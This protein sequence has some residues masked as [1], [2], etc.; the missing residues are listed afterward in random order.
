[1]RL[2][3]GNFEPGGWR[4]ARR[5]WPAAP[6]V[7]DRADEVTENH[8]G[9]KVYTDSVDVFA[10]SR[11]CTLSII[12]NLC[13]NSPQDYLNIL[14]SPHSRPHPHSRPRATP[15]TSFDAVDLFKYGAVIK[16]SH[17]ATNTVVELL[18]ILFASASQYA[19]GLIKRLLCFIECY[20]FCCSA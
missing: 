10:L 5:H 15:W 4:N 8:T 14:C 6:M 1:M 11:I 9:G 20:L 12:Y 2:E 17:L 7:G 19:V 13:A 18:L 16:M 3:G